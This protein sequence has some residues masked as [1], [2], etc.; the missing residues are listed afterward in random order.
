MG[1]TG[2]QFTGIAARVSAGSAALDATMEAVATATPP[3]APATV[4]VTGTVAGASRIGKYVVL[5]QLGEG[6][7]GVVVAAYDEELDRR[8]AIKLLRD[9]N[10]ATPERRTRILRE[11][12]AMARVSHP[13][14]VHVYEV[15]ELSEPGAAQSQVF[16]AM[17]FIDGMTLASWQQ[18]PERTW[19]EILV[20]Y[21]AA[22]QGLL[23][24]HQS[25]LV[26]RDFKP[27]KICSPSP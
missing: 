9:K 11:A 17:E 24:A 26:H 12:Q 13:N 25:G 22:G 23:A 4:T 18:Q 2:E 20:L 21:T 27:E 5:R 3:A 6:G 8:V 16:I 1:K 7:M 14:V 19:E 15:G 10:P